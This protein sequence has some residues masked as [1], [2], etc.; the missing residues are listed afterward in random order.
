MD[1]SWRAALFLAPALFHIVALTWRLT[2]PTF[3]RCA[4]SKGHETRPQQILFCRPRH[5]CRLAQHAGSRITLLRIPCDNTVNHADRSASLLCRAF[6]F[7]DRA[8]ICIHGE[9]FVWRRVPLPSVR[10]ISRV[11]LII[12]TGIAGTDERIHVQSRIL[13]V[14]GE[15][16]CF[17]TL[18]LPPT[19]FQFARE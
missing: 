7:Y 8:K 18:F 5:T 11:I 1:Y 14:A 2:S 4:I 6:F 12:I 15:K 17:Y 13:F 9:I 10:Q 19:N 3:T 16:C